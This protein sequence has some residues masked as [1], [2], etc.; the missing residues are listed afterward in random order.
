MK[1]Q[2]TF[3][4]RK[5]ISSFFWKKYLP[6]R[7]GFWA[8][9]SLPRSTKAVSFPSFLRQQ[10]RDAPLSLVHFIKTTST[11]QSQEEL[12]IFLGL[13][14]ESMRTP[15]CFPRNMPILSSKMPGCFLHRKAQFSWSPILVMHFFLLQCI[16]YLELSL[17]TYKAFSLQDLPDWSM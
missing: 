14:S 4:D 13:R 5:I 12:V 9:S 7:L 2:T 6:L 17:K 8:Q 16:Q 11:Q 1:T 3:K 15:G 10:G